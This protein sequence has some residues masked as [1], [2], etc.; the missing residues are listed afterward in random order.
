MD[1]KQTQLVFL[2]DRDDAAGKPPKQRLYRWDRQSSES[3]LATTLAIEWASRL[4]AKASPPS[5]P[6]KATDALGSVQSMIDN[7]S[8]RQKLELLQE[9]VN[10][11]QKRFGTWQIAWGEVNRYQRTNTGMFDD[12]KPSFPV[13]LAPATWGA[14]PSFAARRFP[15]TNKRY[16]L[17]GNSFI[18]CV[19]FG[20]KVKARSIITG[21][22]SFDPGSPHFTDQA[23]GYINGQ[24]KDVLFYK[25]DVLKHVERSYHPGE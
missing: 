23:E 24:F 12:A 3:S 17:S 2:S 8:A 19:E 1:E 7:T 10:D 25:E 18:A 22:Q 14:L 16:G 4:S 6:Y 5:H 15:N 11:L 21:G 9:T 13:G 20:K